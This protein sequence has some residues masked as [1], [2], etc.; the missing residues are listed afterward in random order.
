MA[1][2]EDNITDKAF[3]EWRS[4]VEAAGGPSALDTSD[5]RYDT[6]KKLDADQSRVYFTY[7]DQPNER[8][9]SLYGDAQQ[10]PA[11]FPWAYPEH[12]D[13]KK[14]FPRSSP[15]VPKT[16]KE[17]SEERQK[18]QF[19]SFF[20]SNIP[21]SAFVDRLEAD[22]EDFVLDVVSDGKFEKLN[23]GAPKSFVDIQREKL[24]EEQQNESDSIFDETTKPRRLRADALRKLLANFTGSVPQDLPAIE[25]IKRGVFQ[26]SEFQLPQVEPPKS[27][28]PKS[29]IQNILQPDQ[30][31]FSDVTTEKNVL[32]ELS[33]Q[34]KPSGFVDVSGQDGFDDDFAP[35]EDPDFAEQAEAAARGEGPIPGLEESP[36][37]PA[38]VSGIKAGL[39]RE[40]SSFV[41][42]LPTTAAKTA[43]GLL[44]PATTLPVSTS[45]IVGYASMVGIPVS[46]LGIA[47]T[48]GSSAFAAYNSPYSGFGP[49]DILQGALY[50][51]LPGSSAED[52]FAEMTE[53]QEEFDL[54][55]ED[56]FSNP[57]VTTEEE[58]DKMLGR[59][60]FGA[61]GEHGLSK[62]TDEN[63]IQDTID[64]AQRS[65]MEEHELDIDAD[66]FGPGTIHGPTAGFPTEAGYD[67]GTMPSKS[68][69]FIDSFFSLFAPD[70]PAPEA[71][72]DSYAGAMG[73]P[74]DDEDD[75]SHGTSGVGQT[76][77]SAFALSD[78]AAFGDPGDDPSQSADQATD[79][80]ESGDVW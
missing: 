41:S 51:L 18:A 48:L 20:D 2:T 68:K 34:F 30:D 15:F 36:E 1:T 11:D 77:G 29:T 44:A 7:P 80:D 35:P 53:E 54:L 55:V 75:P 71:T 32:Q 49:I 5:N 31:N 6:L 27:L 23:L 63:T 13:F 14:Y 26:P 60:F 45:P 39:S 57:F 33:E 10:D 73:F 66:M 3:G 47:F 76:Y 43:V 56:V 16:E 59:G 79:S 19:S 64:I 28:V 50:G 42:N 9:V 8:E 70:P 61:E 40:A 52:F 25:Q 38:I 22:N 58:I 46:P 72:Q 65:L 21:V 37:V 17:L 62:T 4:W 67:Y 12:P 78:D 74:D 24:L 69:G